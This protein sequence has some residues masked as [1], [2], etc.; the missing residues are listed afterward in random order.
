MSS[1]PGDHADMDAVMPR[2]CPNPWH[3]SAPARATMACPECRY[4]ITEDTY[5]GGLMPEVHV[6]SREP[7]DRCY[8]HGP[9]VNQLAAQPPHKIPGTE[10]EAPPVGDAVV[11]VW[12]GFAGLA[13]EL[14]GYQDLE[15]VDP[16]TG[17]RLWVPLPDR[18]R[19]AG[20]LAWYRYAL[21][22]AERSGF[23]KLL[24]PA[25]TDPAARAAH[26]DARLR[27]QATSADPT[28]QGQRYTS[29]QDPHPEQ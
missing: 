4:E 1:Y 26:F 14:G 29:G 13:I 22:V 23:L 19:F 24:A 10:I 16:Y 25:N 27:R 11:H 7:A 5:W 20:V 6:T 28:A 8:P 12:G 18:L 17:R 3:A 21:D 15:L 9:T 2:T